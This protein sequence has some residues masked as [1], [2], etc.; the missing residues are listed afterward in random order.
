M[1]IVKNRF[2]LDRSVERIDFERILVTGESLEHKGQRKI[3]KSNELFS[4]EYEG[5][6]SY[7]VGSKIA[8]E[9]TFWKIRS[10]KEKSNRNG[11]TSVVLFVSP[12]Y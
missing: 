3:N 8:F 5:G 2:G 7:L 1:E 6:P 4:F 9:N 10:M 11:L 12:M